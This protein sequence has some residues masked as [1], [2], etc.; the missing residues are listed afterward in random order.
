MN[1]NTNRK[2]WTALLLQALLACVISGCGG[3]DGTAGDSLSSGN[4]GQAKTVVPLDTAGLFTDRDRSADYDESS[5]VRIALSDGGSSCPDSSV[6]IDGNTVTINAA[7]TYILSGSLS[8]GQLIIDAPKDAKIQLVLDNVSVTRSTSA[9][10]YVRQADKVFLS[11]TAGSVNTLASTSAYEA[12]DDSNIDAA[13]FARCDL[14]INGPGTLNVDSACGHGIVSKDDLVITDG[15]CNVGAEKHALSGKD[16]VR[17]SGGTLNLNAGTDGIHS[18]NADDDKKGFICITEGELCIACG[19]DGLDGDYTVQI[20]GGSLEIAAGDDGIHSDSDLIIADGT[21]NIT[22]S[23]EGLEG[24]TVTI[25][26]GEVT[27]NSAD[28]GINAAG[29]GTLSDSSGTEEAETAESAPTDRE[30]APEAPKDTK[31]APE[32]P[33][34]KHMTDSGELPPGRGGKSAGFGKNPPDGSAPRTG[35]PG[36]ASD[37]NWITINGGILRISADG[38]GIDSNGDLTVTGG[39]IYIDGPDSG[40]NGALDYAGR[41]SITGGT[42]VAVGASGMAQNFGAGSTQGSMLV[43]VSDRMQTGSL[44]LKDADGNTLVSFEPAKA[45]NSVLVSAPFVREGDSYTL[46]AGSTDTVV[47]MT[48]AVTD[49]H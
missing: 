5:A 17:I 31:D 7:G 15:V 25:E 2:F 44:A 18:E 33:R 45:Y 3:A 47:E 29:E 21:I 39:E 49:A 27:V 19:S 37:S 28:D 9:A 30:D 38:D 11:L 22:E 26:C 32:A 46:T 10:V 23:Y 36:E 24:K 43:T 16:S 34:D 4:S 12:I 35:G 1:Y 41:G 8:D 48:A 14:T 40:G 6:A 13:I 20:D 42:V